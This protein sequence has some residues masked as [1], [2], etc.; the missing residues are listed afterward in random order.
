MSRPVSLRA[1]E[2]FVITARALS[3]TVAARQLGLTT[4]AV[5]RRISDLEVE[6]GVD[7]FQRHNRRIELTAAGARYLASVG[8]PIDRIHA[9]SA[10]LREDRAC[11]VVRLSVVPSFASSWLM[12]RLARFREQRPDIDVELD[13]NS[14]LVD[15]SIGD[16]H[17]GLRFGEGGWPGLV[18]ERLLD[19]EVAPVC[20]PGLMP[21]T[22]KV[23][24]EALDR[25]TVLSVVPVLGLWD[26]WFKAVGVG[27]YRPRRIKTF[28]NV[29]VLYEAA[30]AGM[31][32]ALGGTHLVDPYLASGRLVQAFDAPAVAAK[33]GWYLVYR[34]R[35]RNWA[36]LHALSDL[37]FEEAAAEARVSRLAAVR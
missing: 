2:T 3:L 4:S 20:A 12:P 23:T 7:L 17:A 9:G 22:R 26:D 21:T 37:L 35:D 14:D 6:L 30:A 33:S 11:K 1:V 24:A 15:F 32:L 5:S 34:P 8:D 27:G 13:T 25:F 28:D 10:A 36:P 29:Q 18:C 19:T 31:G 16:V